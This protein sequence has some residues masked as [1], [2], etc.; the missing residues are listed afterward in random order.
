MCHVNYVVKLASSPITGKSVA[1]S[2][3]NTGTT[4]NATPST[5]RGHGKMYFDIVTCPLHCTAELLTWVH[6]ALEHSVCFASRNR[7]AFDVKLSVCT[8]RG[9]S[10]IPTP[11]P[12]TATF[13]HFNDEERRGTTKTATRNDE[14]RR[15][16]TTTTANSSTRTNDFR[17]VC[18]DSLARTNERTNDRTNELR[19]LRSTR[20]VSESE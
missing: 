3:C 1:A 19:R 20:S 15:R 13:D 16:G 5:H 8:R 9:H 10:N 6:S 18:G 17:F 11:R 12:T 2:R 14:E 7:R 4:T